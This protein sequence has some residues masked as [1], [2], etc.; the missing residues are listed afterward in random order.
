MTFVEDERH[1][2]AWQGSAAAAAIVAADG[3]A[4]PKPVIRVADIPVHGGAIYPDLDDDGVV[5]TQP[6]AGVFRAFSATCTCTA[7]GIWSVAANSPWPI[8]KAVRSSFVLP[9]TVA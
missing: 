3:P 9:V 5:V 8:A 1:V 2:A 6:A 7:P 4:G